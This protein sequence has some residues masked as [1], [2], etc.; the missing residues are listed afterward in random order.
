M[1]YFCEQEEV[2]GRE[3]VPGVTIRPIMGERA[4][5]RRD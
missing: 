5:S 3:L 2:P 4:G 1:Q